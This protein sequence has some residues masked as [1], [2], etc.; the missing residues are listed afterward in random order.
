MENRPMDAAQSYLDTMRLGI[1]ISRDGLILDRMLGVR[2]QGIGSTSLAKLLPKLTCDQMR[3][4]I[5]Q[6]EQIDAQTVTWKEVLR[7]ESRFDRALMGNN[8]INFVLNLW[9][10]Q[11]R[12]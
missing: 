2:V 6:L 5:E 11:K 7:N 1:K 8:P 12:A 3:P 4:L 10:D 9:I